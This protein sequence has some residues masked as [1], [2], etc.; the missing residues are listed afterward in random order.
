MK[1]MQQE[2]R[3]QT[4][5]ASPIAAWLQA[6]PADDQGI[7]RLKFAEHHI[8]SPFVRALHGGVVGALMELVAEAE[9]AA[10][11]PGQRLELVS[12]AINYLRVTKD[13][14]LLARVAIVRIARRL[15]FVDV[16]CWQQNEETPIAHGSCTLRLFEA[17]T[18]NV[19]D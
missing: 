11:N 15:A 5:F 4:L 17:A 7:Y 2:S 8:G 13:A 18:A 6:Q 19:T 10:K 12:S 3:Q 1:A 9:V 16:W 14:D